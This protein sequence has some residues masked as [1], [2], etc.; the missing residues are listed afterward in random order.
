MQR[1][2]TAD[3]ETTTD[4][5]D[6]RVW[7]YAIC[8]VGDTDNFIYGNNIDDFMEFCAN[9]KQNYKVLFHNLKFDGDFILNWLLKNGFDYIQNKKERHDRSFTTL[10]TDM[11]AFY[12]IEVYFTAKK[13]GKVNKVVF[14]DS[15]KLL[16][17]SVDEIAKSFDLPIRKLTLDYDAKREIGHELTEHEIDYIRNDVEIMARAMEIMYDRKMNKMTIGACA[18]DSFKKMCKGFSKYFP[19]LSIEV[20]AD[21]RKSYKGG[22]TYLSP[23]YREK[24]TGAGLVLDINSMY[25]AM[26]TQRELPYGLP[27]PFEGKYEHDGCYPLYV[28]KFTC[29]FDLKP[30]KIP[31][32]QLKNNVSFIPNEYLESSNGEIVSMTLTNPDLELF[33][34]QY[35]VEVVSWDGGWKFKKMKGLFTSYINYWTEQKIKAKQE[36]NRPQ[37]LLSKLMLNNLYG[38]LATNPRGRQKRPVLDTNGN[39]AYAFLEPEERKPLYIPAATFITSYARKYIIETSQLIRDWSEKHKGFD[40]YCYSDTDSIHTLLDDDDLAALSELIDIDPYRLGAWDCEA[41]FTRGKYLRQKC[42]IEEIDGEIHSTIA[43]LPK[44]LAPLITFDNFRL[45][46][47]TEE[48]DKEEVKKYGSKLRYK[49]VE[50]G[51]VLVPTEFTIK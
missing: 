13:R 11:G 27:E 16:N 25:P 12:A 22:F 6:C 47:S 34:E 49:H 30:D 24:E 39:T 15:L 48:L 20:D 7:A 3:F 35:N 18:L 31:S 14:Q 51:V 50:G 5:S 19:Q 41:H 29:I 1:I 43:G 37:Y 28:Q 45:G 36:G 2:F 4:P 17:F 40:A 46:F 23:K 8:E 38:K 21:I 33:F 44:K 10:I 26:M 9:P 42:Y 32:I